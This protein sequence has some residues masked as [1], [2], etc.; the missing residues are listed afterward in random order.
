M[1][2]TV[3]FAA[4][5][6]SVITSL[7]SRGW[8]VTACSMVFIYHRQSQTQRAP[9]VTRGREADTRFAA[10]PPRVRDASRWAAFPGKKRKGNL[11]VR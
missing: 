6:G 9:A 1:Q 8:V 2:I 11:R 3:L 5:I 4:L 7:P 10:A